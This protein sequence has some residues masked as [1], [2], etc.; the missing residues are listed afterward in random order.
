MGDGYDYEFTLPSGRRPD[1][2]DWN[3]RVVRELKSDAASSQAAGR[4]QLADYVSELEQMTGQ[5]W[6]GVLDTYSR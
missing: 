4:R 5:R 3:N 6:T 2:I 1:A